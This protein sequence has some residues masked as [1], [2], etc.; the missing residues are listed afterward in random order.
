MRRKIVAGNWKMNTTVA[1]GRQLAQEIAD[2][3]TPEGVTLI[4][5]PPYTHLTSVHDVIQDRPDILLS[6]QDCYA[7]ESGA[8]T[9]AISPLMIKSTGATYTI[10]GHSE[11]RSYFQEDNVVIFQKMRAALSAGLQV[12]LCVGE[13]LEQRELGDHFKVVQNQLEETICKFSTRDCEQVI[14]AYEPVWAI[15]TGKTATAD[16]AGEMHGFIREVIAQNSDN[17]FAEQIPILYGGSCKPGNAAELFAQS[18]VDGGL[19]GGASLSAED[20]LAIARSF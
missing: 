16:Q 2:Q 5:A 13:K 15:G 14:L 19:I 1:E 4:L 8:Y 11:R 3:E 7:K 18:N 10:L 12:I 17:R 20:F 6:A 9:G